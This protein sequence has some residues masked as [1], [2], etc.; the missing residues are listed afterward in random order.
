MNTK[1][2][3]KERGLQLKAIVR[4][5]RYRNFRLFFSGQ[6]VSLIGT[7]MQRIA[8]S[9]LVY[10]MTHSTFLLGV[11]S[12]SGQIPTLIFAPIAGVVADRV[13]RHRFLV[14]TQ[15]LAMLQAFVL[16][17]LVMTGLIRVW[18]IIIL[19]VILGIINV[20]DMPTRQ[21]FMIEMIDDKKDLGNAIALNSSMVNGARL[22]GPSIAGLLI[23]LAGEGIC[24]L[25]NG[26]S[27]IAVIGSLLLM[28]IARKE[29][30]SRNGKVWSQIKEGFSY[31]NGF[32]PLRA[33][34]LM[35]A[36]I[37]LMGMPYGVLMPV[38][39]KNILH[40]GPDI[41]G[42]LMGAAGVGALTGAI[43]LASRKTVLGL[44]KMIP[45]AASVF[46]LGLVLFSFSNM[47]VLSLLLMLFTGFGQMVQLASSN[48]LLQTITDDSKR[49]RVMSLY[50]MAFMGVMPIGS[51]IAGAVASKIGVQWTV[52]IGGATC[53]LGAIYFARKLPALRRMVRPIYASMGILPEIAMGIQRASESSVPD[54]YS[55]PEEF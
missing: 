50:G 55:K 8:L 2:G 12:F 43:Y 29:A 36:L 13:N 30:K 24:F 34:I 47:L 53:V 41:L 45:I 32:P 9:W 5:L 11:V 54:K 37:S 27:Y 4:A 15:S 17:F 21:S 19:S 35:L 23:S 1:S 48:T 31:V 16:A 33:I 46:G 6:S 20:L 25:I 49:G 39:A 52:F 28:H 26:I 3:K 7:W 14:I 10:E 40:G 22:L 42:F 18:E 38:F 51:L 44:G